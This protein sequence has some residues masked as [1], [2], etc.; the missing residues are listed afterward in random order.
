MKKYI[1]LVVG[2][3]VLIIVVFILMS[4][5][6]KKEIEEELVFKDKVLETMIKEE[7]DKDK[8]YPSDLNEISGLLIASDRLIGFSGGGYTDKSVIL[9]GF[10]SFEYEGTRYKE[11]GTITSLEDLK[12]FPKLTSLRIYL[13]PNIDF[14]TIPN[15][16]NIYNLGLS[17]NQIEDL[18]FLE[19]F[20]KLMYLSISSNKIVNLEGIENV[21]GIKRL[22]LNSND[23]ED[24]S[25]LE[26]FNN[27][28]NLDLTYNAVKD[29]SALSNLP[30]LEY[31]S[32]YENGISDISPLSNIKSLK[33]LYLNNNSI[34]DISPL[35][36]F[37]SFEALNISGNPITNYEEINHIKNVVK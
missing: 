25:L 6:S 23:V 12:Y 35:K 37:T 36:D 29:V 5:C 8:V 1:G 15:K 13:Q 20:D 31:L 22:N 10:D 11:F 24:I 7:L 19:G 17:Q 4:S 14:D 32:L 30:K 26:G 16:G 21:D 2:I 28:E 33:E 27:L 34:T 9:F 3:I 18:T